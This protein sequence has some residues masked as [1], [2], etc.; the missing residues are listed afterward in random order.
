VL[1]VPAIGDEPYDGGWLDPLVPALYPSQWARQARTAAAGCPLFPSKD[2]VLTRPDGDPAGPSTVAP[3]SY[4]FTSDDGSYAVVWWDPHVLALD[5]DAGYG[6]RR[7]DL[8]AKDG[9]PAAVAARLDEYRR[10]QS[11]RT[12]AL[13][14]ARVPSLTIRT[15]TA[16]AHDPEGTNAVPDAEIEVIDIAGA[17]RQALGARFGSL[18]HATLA[19][20]PLDASDAVIATVADAQGRILPTADPPRDASAEVHAAAEVVTT[21]LRDPLFDRVRAAERAGRCQRE[22][23]IVW[24]APDGT[25]VEGTIDLVFDDDQGTTV[26]DFK[27]DRGDLDPYRRQLSVY[28]H[29][30][31]QIKT[32]P[33]KGLLVR[34]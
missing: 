9:D 12:S 5:A 19:T 25:L 3:G 32:G 23:P 29:A 31:R 2:S 20:V 33:V 15:A 17:D 14:Q 13:A 4:T 27:T 18:V 16:L 30:L 22:L 1:V 10:W 21:V 26:L 28:C 11:S 24:K 8:I 6:L 7:D 34:V